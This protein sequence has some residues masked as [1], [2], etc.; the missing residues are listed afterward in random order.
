[1]IGIVKQYKNLSLLLAFLSLLNVNLLPTGAVYVFFI[2]FWVYFIF[3]TKKM[4]V[5]K[6]DQTHLFAAAVLLILFFINFFVSKYKLPFFLFLFAAF[7]TF[8]PFITFFISDRLFFTTKDV[9]D[10]CDGHIKLALLISCINLIETIVLPAA[11]IS[12]SFLNSNVFMLGY[13]TSYMSICALLCF[14]NYYLTKRKKYIRFLAFLSIVIIASV[15]LKAIAGLLIVY[16]MYV[17]IFTKTSKLQKIL[18]SAIGVG[19]AVFIIS[20]STTIS[21]KISYYKELYGGESSH[22][23]IA[24]VA[25][26]YQSLKMAENCFPF[27]TGQ[28]TFGSIPAKITRSQVYED[29][30]L[31]GVWGLSFDGDLNFMMDTHW[32]SVLGE[33]GFIGSVIYVFL[34]LIPL[35]RLKYVKKWPMRH[36][37]YVYFVVLTCYICVFLESIALPLINRL[38]FVFMYAGL[39]S[40]ITNRKYFEYIMVEKNKI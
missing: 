40:V 20:L 35:R 12:Y 24:R 30:N 10:F 27:G 25:L 36:R 28:G 3:K 8:I 26:Y 13:S 19:L 17:M 9:I 11:H 22:E 33:Q 38:C 18:L 6:D 39:C 37:N 29:Y 21:G 34:L 2:L 4:S 32:A 1:M 5:P 23:D 16:F 7:V 15:Q 31:S 14:G